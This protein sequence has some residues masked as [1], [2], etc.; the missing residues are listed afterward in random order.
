VPGHLHEVAPGVLVATSRFMATSTVV[1]TA[2][3]RARDDDALV[4]DPG[5]HADELEALAGELAE[6]GL[7]VVG[8][9]ATHAHWDHV[10][11]HEGLGGGPHWA[12]PRTVADA[13]ANRADLLGEARATTAVDESRF[14]RLRPLEGAVPWPGPAVHLIVH[15]AHCP[16]HTALHV[17]ERGL[18]VAGDMGSDVEVPLLTHG[19]PGPEALLAH[20]AGIE[21]LAALAPVDVAVPGHG[22][23]CDGDMWRRRLDADR[24]YLDDVAA[25]RPSDDTRLHEPWLVEAD[26]AMRATLTKAEWRRWVR[27]LPT[28]GLAAQ[29]VVAQLAAFLGPSP[30]VLGAY[31]AL[32]DEVDLE[33]LVD[34]VDAELLALPRLGDEGI[35]TWHL[36]RGA[37]ELHHL[38][39]AQPAGDAPA[40][41]PAD[42]DVLLVPGRL[43]DGHG[44]RLGRGGGHYDRVV[45]RLRPGVP[46]VGV[47]VDERVVPRLPTEA[48]DAPM[49]HL[50]TESGVRAV[51]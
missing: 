40:V 23:V 14:A 41:D 7:R 11:W 6:R 1:L 26:E 8:G 36:D 50:A 37:R 51:G 28:P 17:P 29:A 39:I 47:T 13:G 32:P 24:A 21:R 4:I 49:T 42:L 9:I 22:H 38:G 10:L 18:L 43:F 5:V 27:A 45:P 34:A 3:G 25:G 48:H 12:S 46:V 2:T 16:G 31:V 33:P 20:H 19:V 15:D 35:V 44:V 30:G